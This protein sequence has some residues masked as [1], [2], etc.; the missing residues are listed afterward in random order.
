ML[1]ATR[2]KIP[3]EDLAVRVVRD[4]SNERNGTYALVT[5]LRVGGPVSD[6][7]LDELRAVAEKCPIHKLMTVVTTTIT[8]GVERIR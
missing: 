1:Y 6:A 3:V 7:Q 2:K 4:S 5:T 8:T